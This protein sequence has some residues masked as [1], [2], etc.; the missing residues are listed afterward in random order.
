MPRKFISFLFASAILLPVSIVSGQDW[1]IENQS[2]QYWGQFKFSSG[3]DY[4]SGNYGQPTTT[5]IWY[6]P[7]TLNYNYDEWTLKLTIPY[8]R[9]TGAG[10]VIGGGP[11]GPVVGAPTQTARTT[12]SGL[13]DLIFSGSYTWFLEDLPTL[14]LMGKIKIPTA[15]E[16]KGLGTGEADYTIQLDVFRSIGPVSPFATLGYRFTGDPSGIDLKDVLFASLGVGFKANNEW[17]GGIIG[18]YRQATTDFA[19]DSWEFVSYITWKAPSNF[20][21]NLYGAVG[22]STGSPDMGIGLQLAYQTEFWR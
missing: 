1:D 20:S 4:S 6:V 11:D 13:G 8:I 15:D 16:N 12:Q 9:I 3:F 17:S 21:V 7:N 2:E 5:E 18:D 22:F 10:G 14:E 19:E